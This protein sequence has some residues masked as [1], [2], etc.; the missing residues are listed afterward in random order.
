MH[1]Y[2]KKE[3]TSLF[4]NASLIYSLLIQWLGNFE[5]QL[6]I[7]FDSLIALFTFW[8]NIFIVYF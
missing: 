3:K 6:K 5:N 4:F 7:I 1:K 2:K 8:F